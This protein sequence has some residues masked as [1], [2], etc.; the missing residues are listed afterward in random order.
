MSDVKFLSVY[1]PPHAHLGHSIRFRCEYDGAPVV[2][3]VVPTE[4][5]TVSASGSSLIV[6]LRGVT[7]PHVMTCADVDEAY[8]AAG[9][10]LDYVDAVNRA[11]TESR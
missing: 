7:S 10:I 11:V 6:G 3:G 4:I 5:T 9:H 8:V 2:S 1:V